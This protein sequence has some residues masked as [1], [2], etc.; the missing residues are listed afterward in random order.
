MLVAAVAGATIA[1]IILD[2]TNHFSNREHKRVL[3]AEES[4]KIADARR[5]RNHTGIYG[6]I[7]AVYE[8]VDDPNA[9]VNR[10]ESVDLYGSPCVWLTL[11]NGAKYRSY[12]MKKGIVTER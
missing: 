7:S 9:V 10:E 6:D 3:K 2:R 4:A 8:I 11:Q 5:Y 1:S 12:D